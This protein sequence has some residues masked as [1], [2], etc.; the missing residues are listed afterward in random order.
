[1]EFI[2]ITG[3]S[4][5]G[6]SQAAHALE[7]AG[8]YCIDNMPAKLIPDFA[9]LYKNANRERDVAFI[10]DVRGENEFDNMFEGIETL[11]CAGYECKTI[12][13]ECNDDVLINRYKETRRV[14]PLARVSNMSINV[15]I[16]RERAML[17][18]VKQRSDIV[19]DTSKTTLSQLRERVYS[20]INSGEN[21]GIYVSCTSFGFKYGPVCEADLVFD[22]RCFPNPFYV[23]ELK[24]KTGL[25][26][27]VRDFVLS[28]D[29]TKAFLNKL[30]D[31][32]ESL[33]PLYINEG[34]HQLTVAVGCTGGKHRSVTIAEALA[35]RLTSLGYRAV[36]FHRDINKE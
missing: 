30:Y 22:V 36:P 33:L 4:G 11:R 3:M 10:I 1:M 27:P 6:K 7:D 34:K 18:S 16:A 29:D 13:I 32:L 2:I 24:H 23:P 9:E 12:F 19:I 17:K 28:S 26:E 8:Y 15:A 20:A 21:N 14:H 5:A 35:A 25:D 31:M